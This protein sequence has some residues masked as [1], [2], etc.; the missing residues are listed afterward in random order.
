M[1][2]Y[3]GIGSRQTPPEILAKMTDIAKAKA[4]L[5]IILRSG[6]ADGADLAFEAGAGKLKEIWLPWPGFNGSDSDSPLPSQ[7]AVDMASRIHPNWA[8]CKRG[9]RLLHA[10]NCHQVLGANL[11]TPSEQV[12]CWTPGGEVVGGTATALRI[13]MEWKIPILNLG[14]R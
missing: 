4:A 7:A 3:T 2:Y 8:A 6:G 1:R 10:R 9:A 14:S 13:A 5:G 11:M 12:I